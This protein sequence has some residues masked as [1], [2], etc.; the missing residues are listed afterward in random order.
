MRSEAVHTAAV[1][2]PLCVCSELPAGDEVKFRGT[3]AAAKP[4][5]A[6]EPGLK[7]SEPE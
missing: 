6:V 1:Y 3:R 2:K 5:A 4:A 7:A